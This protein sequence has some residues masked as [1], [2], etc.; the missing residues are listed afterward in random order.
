[1]ARYIIDNQLTNPEDL[2]SFKGAGYYYS[3]MQSSGII[4]YF[5]VM[6]YR[7]EAECNSSL[8]FKR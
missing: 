5:C 2:K 3:E 4:W 7:S 8:C 6:L 1:M